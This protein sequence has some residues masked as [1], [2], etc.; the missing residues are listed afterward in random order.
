MKYVTGGL[1]RASEK[2]EDA[3]WL[4]EARKIGKTYLL[5]AD[6][7]FFKADKNPLFTLN[8][9]DEAIF[10]GLAGEMPYFAVMLLGQDAAETEKAF[11]ASDLRTITIQSLLDEAHLTPLAQAKSAFHWHK[12]HQF[13]GVCGGKTHMT[14]AGWQRDC[15]ECKISHF[16][17]TDPAVIMLAYDGDN[18]LLGRS[19]K[20]PAGS[21]STLAGFMEPGETFEAAVSREL[22]EEAGIETT[23][24]KIIYNQPW[25]FPA[26]LMIGCFARATTTKLTIDYSELE[27]ARWFSKPEMLKMHKREHEDGLITPPALSVSHQL[28]K[29]FLEN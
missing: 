4:S 8:D 9:G 16:P 13:C 12:S 20:F 6:K 15:V 21:Y 28:I 10:L 2:R 24:V 11:Q 27:D 3:A 17:R 5:S 1:N 23:D 7:I 29:H 18:A 25:P 26:N 19:A 22:Y 14:K